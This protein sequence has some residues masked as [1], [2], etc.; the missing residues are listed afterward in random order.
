MIQKRHLVWL[1]V[2]ALQAPALATDGYFSDGYGMKAKGMGGAA[3]ARTDDAFGGANNPAT[4]A[5]APDQIAFGADIFSPHRGIS[6]SG[7]APLAS[8]EGQATSG[9]NYFVIPEFG[10]VRQLNADLSAGV[11][12]YG[13]GGMNTSYPGG[14]LPSPGACGPATGPGTG[15]NP[16]AGPYNLLCGTGQMGVNLAQLIVAPTLSWKATP[17]HAIGVSP[18]L[19]Y[20]QFEAYGLQAFGG[21]STKPSAESDQGTDSSTGIGVRLGYAGRLTK[22]LT[23]GVSYAPKVSMGTLNKYAGLFANAGKFDIPANWNVGL[24][25]QAQPGLTLALDYGRIVYSG[26]PS[27]GNSSSVLGNCAAGV[28]ANC[29]GGSAGP[30]FG[31]RDIGVWKLGVQYQLDRNLV[32]RAGY[33]H[34]DNPVQSRDV[35]F[36]MLAPGV[37]QEHVTLGASWTAAPHHEITGAFMYAFNSTVQ[38]ASLFNGFMPPGTPPLNESIH[39]S[40]WSLGAQYAYKF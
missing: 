31:W 30:G 25:W 5:F 4:M 10:Y 35:T 17:D 16:S 26:V 7:A 34:S 21:F 8:L 22:E 39:L 3:V 1:G 33:N 28:V 13:N 23:V 24:S 32:L 18:L 6:R 38:G 14:Q 40:E 9:R 11:T 37:V 15:F 19:V 29:M 12:V 2:L 20:Q 36:N 27:V